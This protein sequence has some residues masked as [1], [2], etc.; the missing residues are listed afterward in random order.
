MM[1][2]FH[3]HALER[4]VERGTTEEEIV[5]TIQSGEQFS[6]KFGRIGFRK[7]F[8]FGATWRGRSYSTK[9]V[10]AFAVRENGDWLVIT[11]MTRYY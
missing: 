2:R 5:V 7:S 4:L 9:E 3:P 1:V 6:A 8:P 10:A 11:V